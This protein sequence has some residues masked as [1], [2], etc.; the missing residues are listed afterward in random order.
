MKEWQVEDAGCGC[1]AFSE[2]IVLACQKTGEIYSSTLP[3]TWDDGSS[4]EEKVCSQLIQMMQNA[5]VARDDYLYVCSGNIFHAF[6][7]WLDENKYNWELSKIEGFAHEHAEYLFHC[8]AV[9]AGFPA[10]ISLVDRNYRDYYRALEEWVY[11]DESRLVLLKDREVRRKP[12]ET[13]YVLKGNGRQTRS[14]L[15]CGKKI[16]PYTPVVVYRCRESGRR[17]RRY[18]HPACTPVE[19]LK[20][21][22]EVVTVPW[23]SSNVEGIILCAG[24]ENYQCAVCGQN[25][26]PGEKTF[27]GYLEEVLITGHLSCFLNKEE[28]FPVQVCNPG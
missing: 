5:R 25:V 13:R 3:L 23:A 26:L 1:R 14:C 28:L 18:F 12:A 7:K 2:V 11:A 10:E 15:K 21:T 8:Q 6:H 20:N 4:L 19:P 17:I 24:T 27:Y 9:A 22:L 16:L